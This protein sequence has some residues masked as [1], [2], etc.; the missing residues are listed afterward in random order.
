MIKSL[1]FVGLGGGTGCMLRY[2]CSHIGLK[3]FPSQVFP[4][5]TFFVNILGC[6]LIGLFVGLA[7]SKQVF[8][9][10]FRLLLATGFCGGFTTFSAF[11]TENFKMIESG[12]W[13]MLAVYILGSVV[14]GLLAFWAGRSVVS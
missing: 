11:A 7:A 1:L 2:I 5:G 6:F 13:L 8:D 14:G 12:Q 10:K 4:L 3:F 9:D